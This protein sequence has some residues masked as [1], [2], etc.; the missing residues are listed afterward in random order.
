MYEDESAINPGVVAAPS[1]KQQGYK[2]DCLLYL[3]SS[4]GSHIPPNDHCANYCGI[5]SGKREGTIVLPQGKP[6]IELVCIF[7]QPLPAGAT[8]QKS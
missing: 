3:S 2:G 4:D 7:R 6:S 8:L 1:A 5:R